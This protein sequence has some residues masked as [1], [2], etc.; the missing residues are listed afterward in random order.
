M[1]YISLRPAKGRRCFS[2]GVIEG[3]IEETCARIGDAELRWVF[4]NCFPN[5][6]DTTVTFGEEEGGADTFIITGDIDA[7]WLRDSTNQVWPYL[8][9]SK[10][11]PKLRALVRGLIWR[12]ATCVLRDPY[13]NAFYRTEE[14]IS[15][16]KSDRTKMLPGVH[17]RKYELDSLASVLRLAA[18]YFEATGDST[19]FDGHFLASVDAIL[20]TIQAEQAGTPEQIHPAYSFA[21]RG[22]M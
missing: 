14:R 10:E 16:W 11:C 22:G 8:R 12:Q 1:G 15:Q 4:G 6:L 7:M 3:V 17:E 5:T 19:P 9:F 20:K 13:A 18:G 21:A 2:S